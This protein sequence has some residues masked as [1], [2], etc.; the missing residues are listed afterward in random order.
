M[1]TLKEMY[2]YPVYFLSQTDR[3]AMQVLCNLNRWIQKVKILYIHTTVLIVWHE[4]IVQIVTM[5]IL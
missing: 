4:C 3:K 5:F 1:N 2:Y